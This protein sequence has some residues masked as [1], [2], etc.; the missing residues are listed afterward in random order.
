MKLIFK[1]FKQIKS[2]FSF[3]LTALLFAIMMFSTGCSSFNRQF[4]TPETPPAGK[5]LIYF[6][7]PLDAS[8]NGPD[9]SIYLNGKEILYR[10]PEKTFWI[11]AIP[12]GTYTFSAKYPMY[13][14]QPLTFKNKYEAAVFFIEVGYE[15][16]APDRFTLYLSGLSANDSPKAIEG[17]FRIHKINTA[18]H[19]KRVTIQQHSIF[20]HL[21]LLEYQ[22]MLRMPK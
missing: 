8:N 17:C 4:L 7:R 3:K 15:Y 14:N 21:G 19:R 10:L 13:G 22:S 18:K 6:Y 11:Y 1:Y 9:P 20:A 12:L 5:S 16:G 2:H